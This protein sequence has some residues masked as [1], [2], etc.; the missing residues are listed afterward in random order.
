[1]QRPERSQVTTWGNAQL[2]GVRPI[3]FLFLRAFF[4]R[5]SD[6]LK[7]NHLPAGTLDAPPESMLCESRGFASGVPDFTGLGRAANFQG[8]V[9]WKIL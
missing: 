3:G 6:L 2:L 9:G 1:M 8:A 7:L 5:P 4:L